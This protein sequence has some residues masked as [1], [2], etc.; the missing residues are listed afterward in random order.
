METAGEVFKKT[1]RVISA[2][3][4]EDG[5]RYSEAH[6]LNELLYFWLS[7]LEQELR[8]VERKR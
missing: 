3:E 6:L 4:T 7:W 2:Q 8:L 1:E 5:T